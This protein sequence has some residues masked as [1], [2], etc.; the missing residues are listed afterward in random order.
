M[1][2][3]CNFGTWNAFVLE[4]GGEPY[5]PYLSEL[6]KKNKVLAKRGVRS[7][8]WKGGRHTDKKGY[9]SIWMP[10]H[11]NARMAGY[12]H[13]HR[14]VMSEH[15]G[16]PLTSEESIHHIN[17]IKDDNRIENLEI[18]T[19]RVHRG[20]VECPHCNKEFAIR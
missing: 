3:K 4:C 7:S 1:P 18:M 8:R 9:V 14:Y 20:V 13:E 2:I 5:K 10:E 16:R 12:V 6:A 15:L 19:K 11:P 17:G